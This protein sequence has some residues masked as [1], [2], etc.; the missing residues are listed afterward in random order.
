MGSHAFPSQERAK[1]PRTAPV[2]T[3]VHDV[4]QGVLTNQT[5]CMWCEAVTN[6]EESY[7]DLSL[8]IGRNSSVGACLRGF[9]AV[10]T[11][12]GADKF[13][14]DACGG[15]QEAQKR[16]LIRSAPA[17]LA[18]HLKRF[19]YAEALGMHTKLTHRVAFPARLRLGAAACVEA[20]SPDVDA[21]YTLFAV[22]VH[23]G[24]GP[25]HGHYVAFTKAAPAAPPPPPSAAAAVLS[26]AAAALPAAAPLAPEFVAATASSAPAP[27]PGRA[28]VQ[29]DDDGVEVVDEAVLQRLYGSDAPPTPQPEGAAASAL[30]DDE[31]ASEACDDDGIEAA[32]PA[33]EP[34]GGDVAMADAA[35]PPASPGVYG[36]GGLGTMGPPSTEHG[37]ILFYERVQPP[38]K[39]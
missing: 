15:L 31:S 16:L 21:E 24:S 13:H 38:P 22:V 28:W 4:F 29:F 33:A 7:L 23:V 19:K 20:G 6:R 30:S 18:L 9:S 36:V 14:C 32:K 25:H 5:R 12:A 11:L 34:Q 27:S 3:W 39:A 1:L 8:D 35:P 26:A 17:V 37:Y 2:R 10:E